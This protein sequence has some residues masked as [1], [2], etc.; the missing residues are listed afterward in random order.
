M[1]TTSSSTIPIAPLTQVLI[2]TDVD[3]DD[4][5]AILY[6]LKHPA[7]KVTGITVTGTGDVHLTP[8]VCNVSNMLTLL[9]N[10]DALTIPVARGARAPMVYS[11]TFPGK[12]RDA[13]DLHY[14]ADFPAINQHPTIKD[15]QQ[16]LRDYFINSTMPTTVLCIGGGSNY[17]RLFE[18]AKSDPQLR[19][20]L[21]KNLTRI[22]MMGGN[23]LPE[24]TP[25]DFEGAQGNI[26]PTMQPTPYY[27][28]KV[29]EWNIFVDVRGAQ[30][31]FASG[32]PITLVALNA[33]T[34][35]PITRAFVEQI[36]QINNPVTNFLY[37]VLT[38]CTIKDGIGTYLDFWDP[39]AACVL[40]NPTLVTTQNLSLRVEQ[41]LDVEDDKS[42]MI[43]VDNNNGHAI[44]VALSANAD[45]VYST[46]LEIIA[47]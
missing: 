20:A 37:A 2:D 44:D 28:N 42:G 8:G 14:G 45:A 43:I 9:D 5:L 11:N 47:R 35:V 46:Y 24:F 23:L 15:A 25:P 13:A 3:F 38:S 27:T 32:V 22:V 34:H 4:Y 26:Q 16:F 6:L 30:E 33:T 29:A 19:A 17:G 7:I 40:T 1:A 10:P 18:S 41:E 36:K 12:D 31:I 39:L 21:D